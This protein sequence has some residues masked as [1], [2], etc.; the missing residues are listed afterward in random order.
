MRIVESHEGGLV[1]VVREREFGR[2]TVVGATHLIVA[3]AVALVVELHVF[4][5]QTQLERQGIPV[6]L[7]CGERCTIGLSTLVL[8]R[9]NISADGNVL[10]RVLLMVV[11]ITVLSA[12]VQFTRGKGKLVVKFARP[13]VGGHARL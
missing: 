13:E 3:D 4:V 12:D 9:W 6:L 11:G 2:Q 8:G 5:A 7:P 1:E 10:H